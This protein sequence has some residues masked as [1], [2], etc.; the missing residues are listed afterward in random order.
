MYPPPAQKKS[1][2]E[3]SLAAVDQNLATADANQAIVRNLADTNPNLAAVDH[4]SY[5]HD[6]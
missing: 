1:A 2:V 4:I 6:L 3:P 5:S